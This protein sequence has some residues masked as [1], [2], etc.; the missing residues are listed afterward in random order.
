MLFSGAVRNSR[1][2]SARD[3]A[4][5]AAHACL[6]S[7]SHGNQTLKCACCQTQ[8]DFTCAKI[9]TTMLLGVVARV[10]LGHFK[11]SRSVLLCNCKGVLGG[12]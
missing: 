2:R 3:L 1:L 10:L 7:P 5:A 6:M 12:C 8:E 9:T 4:A 11:C